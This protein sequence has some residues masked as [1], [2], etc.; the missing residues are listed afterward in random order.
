MALASNPSESGGGVTVSRYWK[1]GSVDYKKIPEL[2]GVEVEKYRG[3]A[4]LKTRITT[5]S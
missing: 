1:Q 3:A 2:K 5:S 4:R